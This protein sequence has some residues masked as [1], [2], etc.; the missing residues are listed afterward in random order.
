MST[1]PRIYFP[2]VD[3]GT[4]GRGELRRCDAT[5]EKGTTTGVSVTCM[6]SSVNLSDTE[7]DTARSAALAVREWER[8]KGGT[9][10]DSTPVHLKLTSARPS[11]GSS[12]QLACAAADWRARR[13][14]Q[15]APRC[16]LVATGAL[17]EPDATHDPETLPVQR[18][19]HLVAK[20]AQLRSDLDGGK[21]R[22]RPV[23]FCYPA[24]NANDPGVAEALTTLPADRVTAVAVADFDDLLRA[25]VGAAR[26]IKRPWPAFATAAVGIAALVGVLWYTSPAI[27]AIAVDAVHRLSTAMETAWAHVTIDPS[28][29]RLSEAAARTPDDPRQGCAALVETAAHAPGQAGFGWSTVGDR[30]KACRAL[31]DCD[32]GA[33]SPMERPDGLQLRQM[34]EDRVRLE[35]TRRACANA[36]MAYP[37]LAR[38]PYQLARAL[39]AGGEQALNERR[40]QALQRAVELGHTA[41]KVEAWRRQ[42]A[43]E[44]EQA[45][46]QLM[47]LAGASDA[48]PDA[49]RTLGE[50]LTC[51][52]LPHAGETRGM[53]PSQADAR[54]AADLFARAGVSPLAAS[55]AGAERDRIAA[56]GAQIPRIAD[57]AAPV[58]PAW[59][60]G[61]AQVFASP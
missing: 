45:R 9:A 51:G 3:T 6:P 10:N 59:C 28:L 52:L 25:W 1:K 22:G 16:H 20:I 5:L 58:R 42:A 29:L 14:D 26:R 32:Q 2:Q 35:E 33:G 47:I 21:L 34:T 61:V 24:A 17:P 46:R 48:H 60:P 39:D 30:V 36:E 12:G 38:L 50:L 11:T 40:R 44:P 13:P 27:P 37:T 31:Q 55:M 15:A 53:P 7:Q 54:L 49:L 19:E 56:M 8:S 18:V 41:A 4:S 43:E 57:T 23:L